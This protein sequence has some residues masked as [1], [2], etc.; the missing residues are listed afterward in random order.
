MDLQASLAILTPASNKPSKPP[1]PDEYGRTPFQHSALENLD[2]LTEKSKS[3]VMDTQRMFMLAEAYGLPNVVRW[4]P[5]NVSCV[6]SV[7]AGE[8]RC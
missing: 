2:L 7:I 8:K 6:G 4:K 1:Q 5:K 3:M